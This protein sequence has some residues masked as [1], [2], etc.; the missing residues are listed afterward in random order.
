MVLN[1]GVGQARA[2]ADE[3]AALKVVGG[4]EPVLAREPA[5]ADIG[6]AGQPGVGVEGDRLPA[7]ELEVELGVVLQ[8]LADAGLVEH[9]PNAVPGEFPRRP[10]TR[11]LQQLRRIDRSAGQDHLPARPDLVLGVAG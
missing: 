1:V 11:Q 9:G 6:A 2:R 3:A 8:V 5:R 10:D 4:A 7:G